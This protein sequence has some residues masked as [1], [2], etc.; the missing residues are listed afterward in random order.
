MLE[1]CDYLMYVV[2]PDDARNP[3]EMMMLI[4]PHPA[5][6]QRVEHVWDTL[7]D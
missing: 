7:L 2:Q 4:G 1:A 6:G 5:P 3:L